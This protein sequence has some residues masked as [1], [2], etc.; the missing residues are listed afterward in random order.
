M[1]FRSSR[2]RSGQTPEGFQSRDR[3]IRER[4]GTLLDGSTTFSDSFK[5]L[6]TRFWS[7]KKLSSPKVNTFMCI[8]PEKIKSLRERLWQTYFHSV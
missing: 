7:T 1:P 3:E 2:S 8:G 5:I 4:S 6:R